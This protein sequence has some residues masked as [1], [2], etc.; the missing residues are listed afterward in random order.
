MKHSY[1][2]N[3]MQCMII[4]YQNQK[5]QQKYFMKN[6]KKHKKFQKSQKP[7]SKMYDFVKSEKIRTVNNCFDLDLGRK[8]C[9]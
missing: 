4:Y 7:R 1:N 3:E 2:A 9:G 6:L 8:C 5:A